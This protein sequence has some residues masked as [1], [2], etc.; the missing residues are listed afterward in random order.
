MTEEKK[1]EGNGFVPITQLWVREKE[2]IIGPDDQGRKSKILF[3]KLTS[4]ERTDLVT[5]LLKNQVEEAQK[6][7]ED[8]LVKKKAMNEIKLTSKDEIAD[9]IVKLLSTSRR[10]ILDLMPAGENEEK[11]TDEER[12][13]KEEEFFQNWKKDKKKSLK[14]EKI[15]ALQK[16]IYDLQVYAVAFGR[17]SVEYNLETLALMC[18]DP[19]TKERIFKTEEDVKAV[20]GDSLDKLIDELKEFRAFEEES[21][22]RKA[23]KEKN[24][25]GSGS[26]VK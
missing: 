4:G 26:S 20:F 3:R 8:P 12:Q 23:A 10:S 6:L 11:L 25:Q 7:E 5:K 16:Q 14:E 18:R 21:K 24:S 9:T 2:I 19:Q 17:A 1:I 15:E 22:V 13:K